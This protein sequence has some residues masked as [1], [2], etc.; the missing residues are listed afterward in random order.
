[1][2][3]EVFINEAY[4][5]S[6]KEYLKY[7]DD[8]DNEGYD[9]FFVV[10]IRI[11]C[12]IYDELDILTPY[13]AH[14]ENALMDNLTKFGYLGSNVLMFFADLQRYY[15]A[16]DMD[17][18]I[19]IQKYLI[20]MFI[21]KK[22]VL[23]LDNTEIDK[24]KKLLFS[25]YSESP[26]MVSTNYMI[27]DNPNEVIDYFDEQ[28]RENKKVIKKKEKE[29]LNIDAYKILNYSMKEIDSMDVDALEKVNKKVYNFF[30]VSENLINKDYVLAK[31]VN[32]YLYPK[33]EAFTG[34][35]YVDVLFVLSLVATLG[36]IIFILTLLI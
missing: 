21:Y 3:Q 28:L 16:K 5:Y 10:V 19:F 31:K 35:G 11:L 26:L 22:L 15:Q 25:P 17:G 32:E 18:F 27:C 23:D 1:M 12:N 24:F 2:E 20:D 7:K 6:I 33:K 13:Y 4:N 9:S 30:D 36:F 29:V 34:N 8:H 14:D